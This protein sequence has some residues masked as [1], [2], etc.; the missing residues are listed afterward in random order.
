MAETKGLIY[1][2]TVALCDEVKKI[3]INAYAIH[4]S[5]NL[6]SVELKQFVASDKPGVLLAVRKLRYGFDCRDLAWEIIARPPCKEDPEQD[7][8]QMLGRVICLYDDKIGFVLAFKDI[9]DKYI[10]P[11]VSLQ[12]KTLQFSADCL[13]NELEYRVNK[14][15]QCRV[16]DPDV[17]EE[18]KEE[19][20]QH[21]PPLFSH[22]RK[23]NAL[24]NSDEALEVIDCDDDERERKRSR[25]MQQ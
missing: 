10:A 15:G 20:P 12:N 3:L 1:L 18:E 24:A 25:M 13:A 14:H 22:K 9:Y 5:N 4:S 19:K 21:Y 11:L 23:R 8:E 6:A 17:E 7:V 16:I 2:K